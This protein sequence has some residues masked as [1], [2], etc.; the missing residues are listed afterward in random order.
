MGLNQGDSSQAADC[1]ESTTVFTGLEGVGAV[2]V[3]AEHTTIDHRCPQLHELEQVCRKFGLHMLLER[4]HG[5]VAVRGELHHVYTLAH[6]CLLHRMGVA[7]CD[8]HLLDEMGVPVVTSR[9]SRTVA[10]K[11]CWRMFPR[12]RPERQETDGENFICLTAANQS[13]CGLGATCPVER[14]ASRAQ[15]RFGCVHSTTGK[16]NSAASNGSNATSAR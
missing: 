16:A 13:R 4:E 15:K 11:R 2:H 14:S 3:D 5:L 12:P 7:R 6:L 8:P 10:S 1:E 9:Q